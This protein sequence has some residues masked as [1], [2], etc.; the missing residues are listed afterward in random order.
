MHF[1]HSVNVW[2][3]SRLSGHRLLRYQ[4]PLTSENFAKP[5]FG[6][7]HVRPSVSREGCLSVLTAA[8]ALFVVVFY[9]HAPSRCAAHCSDRRSP[10]RTRMT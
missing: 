10:V 5:G 3:N 2:G 7:T 9:A 1:R 6:T 8:P 4:E